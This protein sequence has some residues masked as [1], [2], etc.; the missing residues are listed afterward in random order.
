[1]SAYK[2]LETKDEFKVVGPKNETV[3]VIGKSWWSPKADTSV[4]PVGTLAERTRIHGTTAQRIADM[5]NEELT[6]D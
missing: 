4:T 6:D 2:V 3:A 5:M 1:M